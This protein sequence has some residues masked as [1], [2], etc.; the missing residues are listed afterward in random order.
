MEG[1]AKAGVEQGRLLSRNFILVCASRAAFFSSM[2]VILPVLPLYVDHIG[3]GRAMMGLVIGIF[4]ISI[5]ILSPFI[6]RA[7]DERGRKGLML[8]GSA[9]FLIA[10]ILYNF[11]VS[12]PLLLALRLFH[13]TGLANYNISS[14]AFAA[15]IS[16]SHRRGEAMGWF[17]MSN[18]LAMAV[19]PA[20]GIPIY[21]SYGFNTLFLIAAAVAVVALLF[22]LPLSEPKRVKHRADGSRGQLFSRAALFPAAVV[23][24]LSF[25]YGMV[26]AFVSP[27]A[28]ENG[29]ENPGLFFTVWAIA[30]L[31]SRAAA[32]AISDR[33]GRATVIVP[34]LFMAALSMWMLPWA[35]SLPVFTAASALYGL[36]FGAVHPA[37]MALAIDRVSV[38]NR[39]AAMGT[40]GTAFDIGIGLGSILLGLVL[41]FSDYSAMF[42]VTGVAP[43]LGIAAFAVRYRSG[44]SRAG[45]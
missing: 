21:L 17:G 42:Y 19:S 4:T 11:A 10:A 31:I 29:V 8:I 41:E 25:T 18:N 30:L 6:G 43:L 33:F 34:G 32:G 22:T 16:P 27:F 28:I 15:D 45:A 20:L 7:A 1:T 40:F 13:G 35:T 14:S 26:V 24:S 36:S 39:G 38:E 5:V 44:R 9:I 3:G 37:L 2:A 12:I 23:A